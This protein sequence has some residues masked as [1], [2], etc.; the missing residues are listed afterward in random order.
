MRLTTWS[1][2]VHDN[3]QDFDVGGTDFDRTGRS[4]DG[5]IRVDAAGSNARDGFIPQRNRVTELEQ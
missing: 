2:E 1:G 3:A 4:R 5:P